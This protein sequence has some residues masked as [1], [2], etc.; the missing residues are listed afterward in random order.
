MHF[1]AADTLNLSGFCAKTYW[2]I[3]LIWVDVTKTGKP[4]M[5]IFCSAS[6]FHNSHNQKKTTNRLRRSATHIT[7]S[8]WNFSVIL[9]SSLSWKRERICKQNKNRI[10]KGL[11]FSHVQ[12]WSCIQ[13]VGILL[14]D[15]LRSKRP[16][17]FL[18]K[19]WNQY[20]FLPRHL[21][22]VHNWQPRNS[23]TAL[24]GKLA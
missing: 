6:L 8:R 22:R 9:E 19:T 2:G 16:E 11:I 24:P 18:K 5:N 13:R 4:D 17:H 1:S 21:Q 20:E 10:V 23:L 15:T 12:C 14:S 3:V 7:I